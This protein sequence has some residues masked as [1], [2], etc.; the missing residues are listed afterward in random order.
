MKTGPAPLN[1]D[2]LVSVITVPTALTALLTTME[3]KMKT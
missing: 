1:W 2:V 3:E